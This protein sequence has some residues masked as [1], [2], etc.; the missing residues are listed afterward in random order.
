M[1]PGEAMPG[2]S[3]ALYLRWLSRSGPISLT[4]FA[5]AK[6]RDDNPAVILLLTFTVVSGLI[7]PLPRK[8]KWRERQDAGTKKRQRLAETGEL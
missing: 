4:R 6:Y 2:S 5:I 3:T 7:S 8:P 1:V